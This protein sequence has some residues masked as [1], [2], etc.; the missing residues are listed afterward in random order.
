MIVRKPFRLNQ[1]AV[2]ALTATMASAQQFPAPDQPQYQAQAQDQ[3]PP[4]RVARISVV[5]GN[6][7]LEPA[8]VD[9][10][11]QAELNFPL[12]A[13]DRVYADNQSQSELQT[14]GLALR[15]G[16]GADVTLSTLTD[17]VAQF[18]LAQG[19]VHLRTRDLTAPDGSAATVEVDTPN[20][21]I[22]VQR[23]GD[24]RI[25]SYP[26]DDSTVVTVDAGQVE[27][28]GNNLD[29]TLTANQSFRLSGSNPVYAERLRMPPTDRLDQFD[30]QQDAVWQ[31][32]LA[33]SADY[34]DPGM[35]GA[36]DLG[37][38]GDW[39]PN[40]DYGQVWFPRAVSADWVP[41][42]NGHW[43]WVAPWGW[44]WVEAEPWGFAPF[45]YGRWATFNGRWGWVPGPSSAIFGGRPPRPVYSPALVAFVGGPRFSIALG[46]GG[47]S[48]AG[49]TAW[50]P[51]GPRE[52]Y[53]PWYHASPAYVNR[54]NVTNIYT[55]DPREFRANYNNR[56]TNVYVSNNTYI[57][58]PRA[59]TAVPQR[60]FA[61]GRGIAQSQ[62]IRMDDRTRGQLAQAPI[63]PHPQVTPAAGA[64]Q[65]QA[66]ARALPP[67]MARPV[68]TRQGPHPGLNP[69][70]QLIP[71]Q[72]TG[73]QPSRLGSAAPVNQRPP[74]Q[75][76]SP[77]QAAPPAQTTPQPGNRGRFQPNQPAPSGYPNQRDH[78]PGTP[79]APTTTPAPAQA[80]ARA[81][82]PTT[83]PGPAQM[84]QPSR[85]QAPT[86]QPAPQQPQPRQPGASTPAP[87]P[88]FQRPNPR[89]PDQPRPLVNRTEPQ[90]PQPSFVQQQQAIQRTEPGRPLGPQQVQNL[91]NGQPAGPHTEPAPRP[92]PAPANP[93]ARPTSNARTPQ[94]Q[95]Q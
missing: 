38:Y 48:G 82:A 64:A 80:P 43:A 90:Q 42:S 62:H 70:G 9:T 14:S 45:H 37:Q 95:P 74:A 6:V 67:S 11:S 28:T 25:D 17:Q 66:P 61:A 27:V 19:S 71:Q 83:Q 41:Y 21:T 44:T 13:G 93:P 50:F 32:A 72:G 5:N 92:A 47:D 3:D 73:S 4:S 16:N 53:T 68:E 2:L 86:P 30:Q 49:V 57:N 33:A 91:R 29:Q 22:V 40:P 84:Q 75:A 8:G 79:V 60:D 18:G 39:S 69:G 35:I 55:R 77:V 26:Q 78:G 81:Q 88:A 46:F 51:L 56:T 52:A 34:V 23:A 20:G 63:L 76:Q 36:A 12:T 94:S 65:P 54:V 85:A 87:A 58:R 59:T 10:F 15:L 1:L 89:T 7:S 31:Q 24:V